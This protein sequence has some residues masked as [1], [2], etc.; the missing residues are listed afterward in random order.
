MTSVNPN[1]QAYL[2]LLQ[3]ILDEGEDRGD[4]T[5]TGTRAIFGAH[6]DFDLA[7][8]F[9]AWTTRKL[10]WRSVVGE[11]LWFLSGS[12]NANDLQNRFGI[13]LWQP[14]ADADGELGPIY[15]KQLR[16][17]GA[18]DNSA[19]D[20]IVELINGLKNNPLSRRH[21]M[22]LWDAADLPR[23]A[24]PPCHGIAIQFFVSNDHKL[25]C[26]YYQRSVDSFLGLSFNAPSYAL[27][28][29]MLAAHCG[30]GVGRL[31]ICLGDTHI[32]NNHFDQVH[33]QLGRTPGTP[34]ELAIHEHPATLFDPD[35]EHRIGD[36]ELL[37]YEHQGEI[38]APVAI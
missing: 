4:R 36:F 3:R 17:Y 31:R 21:V 18:D 30:F 33:E 5:G 7:R 14:W 10:Q 25:S 24:L 34:P 12:T 9:P 2:D 32:Y 27:L 15:G 19:V 6:L 26:Q 8:G 13:K 37:G 35:A 38:S 28:T 22:S 1:E 29:H 20:Q 23:M 11:L 16:R